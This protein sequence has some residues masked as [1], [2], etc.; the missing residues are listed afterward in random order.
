MALDW[1]LASLHHLAV[2]SLAAILAFE[3]ALTAGEVDAR[4]V[5]R[6]SRVDA[7]YGALAA[8]VL[9]VGL[10]RVFLGDKGPQYYGVNALFWIKMA[11]FAAIAGISVLPTLRFILWRRS[12]R[13]DAQ[14]AASRA[15]IARVRVVLWV[16][17]G[18]FALIPIAAAGLA[19]GYGL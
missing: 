14:F 10:A 2:F 15:E 3:L 6:L 16:E 5:L 12:A 9:A 4:A 8:L 1:T 18:L 17:V 13:L 11:L 7:S 19:R